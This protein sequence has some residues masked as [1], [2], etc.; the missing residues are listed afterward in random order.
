V[1]GRR[2][3]NGEVLVRDV[4][5]PLVGTVAMDSVTLESDH[6]L[7]SPSATVLS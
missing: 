7:P 4:R 5:L 6:R 1:G 2:T 3:N